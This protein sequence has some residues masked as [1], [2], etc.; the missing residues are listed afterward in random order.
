MMQTISVEKFLN[1]GVAVQIE[2]ATDYMGIVLKAPHR[3]YPHNISAIG[4]GLKEEIKEFLSENNGPYDAWDFQT[5]FNKKCRT[6]NT[7]VDYQ[8]LENH[9]VWLACKGEI[10]M[11]IL[12]SPHQVPNTE[13]YM[14]KE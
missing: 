13:Y 11:R 12:T 8:T 6:K 4:L 10:E 9:L 2:D 3:Y 1:E 7:I 14:A 5:E